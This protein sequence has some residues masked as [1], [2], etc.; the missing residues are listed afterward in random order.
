MNLET[1]AQDVLVWELSLI[2]PGFSELIICDIIFFITQLYLFSRNST[3]CN[4]F[5][6]V[7][8]FAS[9]FIMETKKSYSINKDM[10]FYKNVWVPLKI[11][12]LVILRHEK[13]TA[14][15]S[16][17]QKLLISFIISL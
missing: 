8:F 3:F 14:V 9:V 16:C 11:M 17:S 4:F 6:I 1:E 15:Y 2:H 10:Y 5:L 13:L 7:K 12:D